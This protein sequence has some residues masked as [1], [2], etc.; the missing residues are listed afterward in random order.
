MRYCGMVING[1]ARRNILWPVVFCVLISANLFLGYVKMK[2]TVAATIYYVDPVGGSDTNNGSYDSPWKTI[3]LSKVAAG[4]TLYLRSG[5]YGSLTISGK[6]YPN[7]LTIAAQAGHTPVFN[8]ILVSNSS[9]IK[10]MGLTSTGTKKSPRS[11]EVRYNLISCT[12]HDL[13]IEDCTVYSV[14][15]VAGWSATNWNNLASSGIQTW[16][17]NMTIRGNHVYN[18]DFGI[19][20]EGTGCLMEYNTIENYCGDGINLK[21][22]RNEVCQ[23]NTIK[24]HYK[25]NDNHGDMIQVYYGNCNNDPIYGVVLRGNLCIAHE[26]PNQPYAYGIQGIGSFDNNMVDA[27]IENNVVLLSNWNGIFL[28]GAVGARVVNNTVLDPYR[29][30][31]NV[32]H[33]CISIEEAQN[34][35]N[36]NN[37][38]VRN[39][40]VQTVMKTGA[41]NA[42]ID[43]NLTGKLDTGKVFVNF[44]GLNV[45]LKE[46][47]PAIDTG[48]SYLAP[49]V[50]IEGNSRP[51]GAGY[52]IG[53]YE[54]GAPAPQPTP[55]PE[56]ANYT[57]TASSN[58]PEGGTVSGAGTYKEGEMASLQAKAASGY[59][60]V[61]WTEGTSVVSTSATYS[62]TATA[63][64]DL[65]ANFAVAS[66]TDTPEKASYTITASAGT[67]GSISPSG[68]VTI[69]A[70]ASQTF[71]ITPATGYH[72]SAVIVDGASMGAV[73]SYTFKDVNADHTIKASFAADKFTIK[74]SFLNKG[75]KVSPTFQTV[76]YGGTAT[77]KII[78]RNGY[79]I[80]SITDNGVSM[81]VSSTYT[82]TNVTCNHN[83]VVTFKLSTN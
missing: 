56:P 13:V 2:S 14:D 61:N 37:C 36:S 24:N 3:N 73:T 53:A 57:I 42:T 78:P 65:V 48:S 50:D 31:Q 5:N 75:G 22:P 70:G 45:R 28:Y 79:T 40:I 67:G 38:V 44:E 21:G 77:I 60:F 71:K 43:H 47:S 18:V 29:Y 33:P 76:I 64:R 25:T 55:S 51:Q 81:P 66:P 59:D 39:N 72:V 34:G 23:Y 26:N 15:S 32:D 83:I 62:F 4:D 6:N 8:G 12:G 30:N 52:D 27:I 41:D 82:I 9:K 20:F 17:D 19:E 1:K 74:A 11:D 63:N 80:A 46:G 68:T 7:Y 35:T 69:S 10:L 16:G 49:G 58:P 54:Y